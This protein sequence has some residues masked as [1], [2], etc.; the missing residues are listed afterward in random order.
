MTWLGLVAVLTLS[1]SA[2]AQSKES[3]MAQ[4]TSYRTVKVDGLNVPR[5]LP[6]V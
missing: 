1:G 5:I 6:P 2:L 4:H 3:S